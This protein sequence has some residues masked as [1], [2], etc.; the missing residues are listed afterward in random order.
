MT[1]T[2]LEGIRFEDIADLVI[3]ESIPR[4]GNKM[5][6]LSQKLSYRGHKGSK[7]I[8]DRYLWFI[9]GTGAFKRPSSPKITR[10]QA[11]CRIPPQKREGTGG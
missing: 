2:G 6:N 9:V 5:R 7:D 11:K 10:N 3:I 4:R 8:G 1:S